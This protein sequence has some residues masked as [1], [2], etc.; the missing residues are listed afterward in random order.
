MVQWLSLHISIA[1]GTGSTSDQGTDFTFHAVRPRKPKLIYTNGS[2]HWITS[3]TIKNIKN[4]VIY[5]RAWLSLTGVTLQ[6][7]TNKQ[8]KKAR[9][10]L[11]NYCP[12]KDYTAQTC[13][14][15][16]ISKILGSR[17]FSG[18][19]V[20]RNSPCNA[21]DTGSIP[22]PGKVHMLQSS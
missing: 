3:K 6:S 14:S 15:Y 21:G 18:G 4:N 19:T 10:W 12:G 13:L 8:T 7:L 16:S 20:D 17:D 22:G 11:P 1:G 2:F 9:V 5:I